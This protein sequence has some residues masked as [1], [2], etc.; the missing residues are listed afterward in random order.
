[1]ATTVPP[2]ANSCAMLIDPISLQVLILKE[3]HSDKKKKQ[4]E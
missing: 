4:K 1:M 2:K 3:L